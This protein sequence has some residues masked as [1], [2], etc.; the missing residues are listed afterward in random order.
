MP[1][2]STLPVPVKSIAPLV[3]DEPLEL[4]SCPSTPI[5]DMIVALSFRLHDLCRHFADTLH[6]G[7]RCSC[8]VDAHHLAYQAE[9]LGGMF[10]GGSVPSATRDGLSD[11]NLEVALAVGELA[12]QLH[13]PSSASEDAAR[14]EILQKLSAMPTTY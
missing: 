14:E 12:L 11:A 6:A 7:C 9:L 13:I 3:R 8:C 1:V 10:D 4:Q 2:S 5:G